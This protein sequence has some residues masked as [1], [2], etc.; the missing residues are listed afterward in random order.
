M[1]I[2]FACYLYKRYYICID[3]QSNDDDTKGNQP[4]IIS[5]FNFI[6]NV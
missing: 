2:Q 5:Q 4:D 6:N 1:A 3:I